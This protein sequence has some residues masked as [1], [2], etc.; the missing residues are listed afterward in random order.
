MCRVEITQNYL[1]THLSIRPSN[2]GR[3]DRSPRSCL[4]SPTGVLRNGQVIGEAVPRRQSTDELLVVPVR[5]MQA[6]LG[7]NFLISSCFLKLQYPL[8][9]L[10]I[11]FIDALGIVFSASFEASRDRICAFQRIP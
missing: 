9:P 8:Q 1:Y 3:T 11:T 6:C 5:A 4:N 2:F 10:R 7:Y